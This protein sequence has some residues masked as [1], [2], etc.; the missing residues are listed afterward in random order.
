MTLL[1]VLRQTSRLGIKLFVIILSVNVAISAGVF[2]AISHS[3]DR[4]FFE[5]LTQAQQRQAQALAEELQS[6]WQYHQGWGWLD[7]EPDR[8]PAVVRHALSDN[9]YE[10]PSL[11][12]NA[13]DFILRDVKGRFVIPPEQEIPADRGAWQWLTLSV[14]RQG[15][16][17]KNGSQNYGSQNNEAQN[18]SH[19]KLATPTSVTPISVI[20]KPSHQTIGTL[21]FRPPHQVI[22]RIKRRLMERQQR[23]LVIIVFSLGLASLLLAGGLAWWLGRRARALA[24]ATQRL[25]QGDYHSR[26][27]EQGRDELSR[28]A[29]DFNL[30]AETLEANREAR[31]RW[32]SDTAH[33]LRT[34][35]AVLKGEIEAMQD[36]VRPLTQDNLVSLGQEVAQLERLVDDLRLL[37]QSDAGALETRLVPLNLSDHLHNCLDDAH[38]WLENS[39]LT[40]VCQIES[41]I[42]IRGDTQRLRQLWRNLLDNSCTYT[43]A[44]GTLRVTL[45]RDDQCVQLIWEDSAPGVPDNE[46]SRLTER[47]Y[48]VEGSRNRA[49][50]GSGLGLSIANALA[51]AHGGHLQA[52]ASP[53]GGLRWTMSLALLRLSDGLQ[54]ERDDG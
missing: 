53:L 5:Y 7:E 39:G 27:E 30:L 42:Q 40:L 47:L 51:N 49:S 26:L 41:D 48:R 4:G 17:Q 46:L 33:E 10:Q 1:G 24:T 35:L 23:N 16:I 44:P 12:G 8:W 19:P 21:G 2:I 18:I 52:S 22:E 50:G 38:Y 6:R 28:L 9:H 14:K 36:G 15:T 37:S 25:T 13:Q 54:G 43:Q 3:I 29:R 20:Q 34:P 31:T 11:F 45:S 32:V